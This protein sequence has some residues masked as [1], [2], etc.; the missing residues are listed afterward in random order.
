MSYIQDKLDEFD[1]IANTLVENGG[2]YNAYE[3]LYPENVSEW[4]EKAF[5]DYHNHIVEKINKELFD[6]WEAVTEIDNPISINNM[7]KDFNA[8]LQDTNPKE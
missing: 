3:G 7:R 2:L 1:R 5:T 4:I 8:L 6:E